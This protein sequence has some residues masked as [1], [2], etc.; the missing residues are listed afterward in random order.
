MDV[1]QA[2]GRV[3]V[4]HKRAPRVF[5]PGNPDQ[6]QALRALAAGVPRGASGRPRNDVRVRDLVS[7]ALFENIEAFYRQRRHSTLGTR[8]AG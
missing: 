3:R 1:G 7:F 6:A 8:L 2:D 5:V 4:G